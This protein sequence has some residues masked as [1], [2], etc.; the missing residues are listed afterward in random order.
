M[1]II[2]GREIL[3]NACI[4]PAGNEDDLEQLDS[5]KLRSM[6]G[7]SKLRA[8][9]FGYTQKGRAMLLY[10]GYAYI[11]DRQAQKSC[12]W[13]CSLFG[14][15]KCR[16]RAVTKEVNGRQMMKITKPLHNHTRDVYSFDKCKKSKE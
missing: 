15:L 5:Q 12:N 3:N 1:D 10:N 8:A 14:K 11:K 16:A 6:I 7:S 2:F 13:K 4:E 9:K